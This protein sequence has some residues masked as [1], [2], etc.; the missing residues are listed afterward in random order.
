MSDK[1]K[2]EV[3]HDITFLDGH[4]IHSISLGGSNEPFNRVKL[5][6][7]CH[8]EVHNG[9]IIIEGRFETTRGNTV[10]WHRKG[11]KSVTGVEPPPV[12]LMKKSDR[13][14]SE[15]ELDKVE[16][17]MGWYDP[18]AGSEAQALFIETMICHKYLVRESSNIEDM[19]KHIDYWIRDNE[20]AEEIP[21]DVKARKRIHRKGEIQDDWLWIEFLNGKGEKGW[22]DGEATF[23]VFE[24]PNDFIFVVRS[25]LREL[26]YQLVDFD[27]EVSNLFDAKYKVYT[28]KKYKR[29]DLIS[30]IAMDT[31]LRN[32]DYILFKKP[33]SEG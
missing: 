23:I 4:H 14:N 11:E 27:S 18:I 19:K 20:Y 16:E 17:D 12:Y 5:C 32:V 6:G 24:R 22:I 9:E 29:K 3:C 28:R 1:L 31:V 8:K 13:E 10:V 2:C 21:V 26:A 30:L 33:N 15:K 25:Q 7:T